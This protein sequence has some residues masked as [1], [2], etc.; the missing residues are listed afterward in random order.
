MNEWQGTCIFIN[1]FTFWRFL[2][3]STVCI[4]IHYFGDFPG[5][6]TV[7]KSPCQCRR[8]CKRPGFDPWVG[9]NP[10]R[11]EWPSTPVFLPGEFHGQRWAP[12]QGVAKSWAG[13][14]DWT[15]TKGGNNQCPSTD[16]RI[17]KPWSNHIVEYFFGLKRIK[18]LIYAITWMNLRDIVLNK[19]GHGFPWG[20]CG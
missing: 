6:A 19:T 12:V 13:L 3:M 2:K 14:S 18:I 1:V 7:K 17:F 20:S 8:L 9:K 16:R 4:S 15:H 11:R 5:G 10:W